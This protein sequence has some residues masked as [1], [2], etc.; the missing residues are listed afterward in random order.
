MLFFLDFCKK[1]NF[2]KINQ[3]TCNKLPS[4][5][6]LRS[7]FAGLSKAT[8]E[9]GWIHFAINKGSSLFQAFSEPGKTWS[10]CEF[11]TNFS[12][13]L[14]AQMREREKARVHDYILCA[15]CLTKYKSE[16][17]STMRRARVGVEV[18]NLARPEQMHPHRL[19]RIK[20]RMQTKKYSV[21]SKGL[22]EQTFALAFYLPLCVRAAQRE[23]EKRVRR[24]LFSA[25]PSPFS[26]CNGGN[27][28]AQKKRR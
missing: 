3:G 17:T 1:S 20:A 13:A 26:A 18:N 5:M 28:N 7:S 10:D 25:T 4:A 12:S 11:P 27:F 9:A 22:Q 6:Q 19:Q 21:C 23:G 14:K 15:A 2:L 24:S 16:S 8:K